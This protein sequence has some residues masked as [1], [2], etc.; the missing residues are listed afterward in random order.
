MFWRNLES[1]EMCSSLVKGMK[2][3]P[4]LLS[5]VLEFLSLRPGKN[6]LDLTLGG[7][8]HADAILEATAPGGK[9][10]GVD[11]D[12]WA[13]ARAMERLAAHS[14]R[15]VTVHNSIGEVQKTFEALGDVRVDGVL[16]DCG[17]S[18]FQ[19]DDPQRGFSFSQN[20]PLDM[21]MDRTQ[22]LTAAKWLDRV[23]E[24]ELADVIYQYGDERHS[25]RIAKAIVTA[26]KKGLIGGTADLAEVIRRAVPAGARQS[27]IHPATRSF[28]AI[29]IA[30]NDELGQLKAGLEYLLKT[31]PAGARIVVIAFHSLEDRIVKDVFRAAAKENR[32]LLL[33]KKPVVPQEQEVRENPRARSAKLRALEIVGGIS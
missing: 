26:K 8:G 30:V 27:R 13:L 4:V 18:S 24:S 3:V 19:L 22:D 28:Q 33:T 1:D 14:G 2:H 29:R 7:G 15:L 5:E 32:V 20:G 23:H 31:L 16:I 17:V 11:R 10:F 25:R 12:E 21:R 6:I 9:L